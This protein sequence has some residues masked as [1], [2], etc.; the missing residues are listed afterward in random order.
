MSHTA[1]HNSLTVECP[2]FDEGNNNVIRRYRRENAQRRE[3]RWQREEAHRFVEA[4]KI[5]I[6]R[7]EAKVLRL[8]ASLATADRTS[9]QLPT[10]LSVLAADLGE[11]RQRS[12]SIEVTVD[13]G[14]A[15]EWDNR[16]ESTAGVE[17]F[18]DEATIDVRARRWLLSNSKDHPQPAPAPSAATNRPLRRQKAS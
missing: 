6:A 13:S 7:L 15:E 11:S 2:H 5:E 16:E 1:I 18:F 12:C 3:L 10:D 17:R 9:D 4:Q 14:F 8:E